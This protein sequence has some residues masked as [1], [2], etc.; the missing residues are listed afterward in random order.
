MYFFPRVIRHSNRFESLREAARVI[1]QRA[2]LASRFLVNRLR[3]LHPYEIQ[4][5]V[6]TSCNH[7]CIYCICPEVKKK[8]LNTE[9]WKKIIH[10]LGALGCLRFK[11]QGGEPT[12]R[13]DFRE[14]SKEAKSAGMIAA[15]ISNGV[16]FASR[17]DFLDYLDELVISLD[18]T[19]GSVNDSIR[20]KGA[21]EAAVNAIDRSLERGIRT[22]VN[23]VVLRD[24]VGDIDNMLEF[25]EGRGVRLNVQPAMFDRKYFSAKIAQRALSD[26]E[27]R[28][29]HLH[30]AR[31]K[32]KGRGFLFSAWAYQKAAD[33]H[34]NGYDLYTKK[35]DGNSSCMSGRCYFHI[36]PEGNVHPCGHHGADFTPKNIVHDGFDE[37]FLHAKHHNCDDCWLPFMNERKVT[38]G[39]RPFA[40]REFLSRS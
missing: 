5:Y 3:R 6:T 8:P 11:I 10:R 16:L 13:E 32:R 34:T 22:F 38:F 12:L 20:G 35:S 28:N 36:E 2:K 4:A 25:C 14:L 15:T 40:I 37:A 39:L 30:L 19:R 26:R 33:W 29:V 1:G 21:Y 9:E 27:I 31:L 18:S 24:N 7:H 23:M 17:P